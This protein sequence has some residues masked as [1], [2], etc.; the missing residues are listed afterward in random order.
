MDKKGLMPH[1]DPFNEFPYSRDWHMDNI[2][3]KAANCVC[4]NGSGEC[5]VPSKC[6]LDDTGKCENLTRMVGPQK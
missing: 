1:H 5:V 4:N 3:C 2:K 6:V